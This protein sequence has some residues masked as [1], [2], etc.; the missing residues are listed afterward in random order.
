MIAADF[1]LRR[2]ALHIAGP[3]SRKPR[4]QSESCFTLLLRLLSAG[5]QFITDTGKRQ[6][7]DHRQLVG[8]FE[9]HG[10]LVVRFR[11]QMYIKSR[12]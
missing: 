1:E 7:Q 4:C 6:L 8:L 2:L 9:V 12:Y 3:A 5:Y 11:Q 10:F